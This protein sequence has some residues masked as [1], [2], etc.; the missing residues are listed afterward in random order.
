LTEPLTS[1]SVLIGDKRHALV[2]RFGQDLL[3][4]QL[5]N[6]VLPDDS[7]A[8]VPFFGD[9][10]YGKPALSRQKE[11]RPMTDE[12]RRAGSGR[13][14]DDPPQIA[15]VGVLADQAMVNEVSQNF[16]KRT[17]L[18]FVEHFQD[19]V[20]DLKSSGHSID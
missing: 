3:C 14:H 19:F 16:V 18:V 12:H 6:A 17:A 20:I 8:S 5:R 9:H 1:R 11:I 13:R 7:F 2:V 15:D 10:A 4:F